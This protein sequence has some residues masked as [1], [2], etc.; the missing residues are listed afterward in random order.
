MSERGKVHIMTLK[1]LDQLPSVGCHNTAKVK[2]LLLNPN[3]TAIMTVNC[4]KMTENQLAPDVVLYGYTA[5]APA[6]T[7]VE[8]HLDG[9]LSAADAFRDSYEYVEQVDAVLVACFSDHPLTHCLREEF[10]IPVCGIFEAGIYS[11]RMIGGTFGVLTTV[12]RSS[13]RHGYA[14]RAMGLEGYCAGLLSTNLK[15]A[16]LHTKPRE[17]VLMLMRKVALKLVEECGADVLVL[18][19]AG[20]A[21]MQEAV[22]NA[23]KEHGVQVVD[24]VVTGINM[25]TALVRCG[26]KTSQ[27]GLFASSKE[28]RL[29]RGQTYL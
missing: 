26:L 12:A 5:K 21:D 13:I 16:E 11:A 27:K 4:L 8:C 19:C 10:D 24:G 25:L 17:E 18:G 3:S 28:S 23:V 15:V 2:I 9:V 20:M 7:T 6:P 14:I 22:T 1:T 29:S